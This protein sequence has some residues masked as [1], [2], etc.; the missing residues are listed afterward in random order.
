MEL[1]KRFATIANEDGIATALRAT[2][3]VV[4]TENVRQFRLNL[5]R[6]FSGRWTVVREIQGSEMKL[7]I[8]PDSPH[9]IERELALD[10]IREPGATETLRTVLANV[11]ERRSSTIHVFDVG[12]NVGYFALLEAN[13]LGDQGQIYAIEAEPEN[14]A[15]LKHN[16]ERNGYENIDVLQI[17]A[18]A[19]RTQLDLSV[20]SSSNVHRISEI[21]PDK[22]PVETVPVD[23]YPL[24]AL[25]REREI[26]DD[27]LVIVRIDV[28]G[29]E[30]HVFRGMTELLTSDQPVIVCV[31]IH[32]K[33]IVNVDGM[34]DLLEYNRYFPIG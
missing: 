13:I 17:A 28:E 34:I 14:A 25:I 33:E 27:E 4:V 3:H 24:D 20:K 32:D 15:R 22:E 11:K 10:G 29:Y 21:R 5:M 6:L 9:R 19:E 8:H 26:P 7:N 18:G 16:V 30:T 2:K 1:V 23:A 12:A 31:E